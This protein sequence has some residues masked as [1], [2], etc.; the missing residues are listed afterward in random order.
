MA[1]INCSE[2]ANEISDKAIS[3]PKCGAPVVSPIANGNA[4]ITDK[5]VNNTFVWLL[6]F[7]PIIA[8][9][10]GCVFFQKYLILFFFILSCGLAILDDMQLKS[11][12]YKTHI[13]VLAFLFVPS[14]IWRRA[15]LTKQSKAYFWVWIISFLISIFISSAYSNGFKINDAREDDNDNYSETNDQLKK[16]A[17]SVANALL[18]GTNDNEKNNLIIRNLDL[19]NNFEKQ[20]NDYI[21][22]DFAHKYDTSLSQISNQIAEGDFN[23]DGKKDAVV[24]YSIYPKG[25]NLIEEQGLYIFKN[26]GNNYNY[27]GK[28]IGKNVYRKEDEFSG[29][30]DLKELKNNGIY[31]EKHFYGTDDARCCP[32]IKK[33]VFLQIK[34]GN[35]IEK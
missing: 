3:C 18:K 23:N 34:N 7:S 5:S 32:S 30:F 4:V 24:K 21:K 35:I 17:D 20:F 15:T 31:I 33:N 12:G 19:S 28:Y 27:T 10:I 1:L 13:L 14:Y 29:G 6:A 8:S 11:V 2:C 9:A 16:S 26:D 25:G 22:N